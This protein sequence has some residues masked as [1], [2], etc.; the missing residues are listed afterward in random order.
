MTPYLISITTFALIYS[1]LALGL[2]L[3]WGHTGLIN[4]G[5]VAFF[6]AGAYGT[7][8]AARA[9]L[10]W[11]LAMVIS[12]VVAG[13]L[14]YP[15][16]YITVRLRAD[17]LA[18]VTLAFSEIVR[19]VLMNSSWSGAAN[20]LTGI[21]RLVPRM[22]GQLDSILF[23]GIAAMAVIAVFLLFNR[24]VESPYG[25]VLWAIRENETAAESLGKNTT[26]IKT[27]SLMLGAAA[28]GLAGCLYAYHVRYIVPD[29]FLPLITFYVWT[30]I[31]LGG[32]SHLGAAL[33]AFILMF[34]M[35]GSR[36]LGDFGF[37]IS[38]TNMAYIRFLVIGFGMILLLRFRP[39]GV[40]PYR[41]RLASTT[42]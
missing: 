27:K 9:G 17:Y 30:G 29:Q 10:P 38:E 24:L 12:I 22:E 28:A 13:F 6:A 21:P 39:E 2:N 36:F 14:A 23:L 26:Q 16:G 18:I 8:I 34:L 4:F 25:R 7:A 5:H 15:L 19:I 20:G 32:S 35:E 11:P 41:K 33:G 31:I 42:L 40:L 37:P 1:L 3:Q